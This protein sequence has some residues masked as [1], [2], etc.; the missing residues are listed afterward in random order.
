MKMEVNNSKPTFEPKI[1]KAKISNNEIAKL[2]DSAS[3]SN[4]SVVPAKSD[5]VSLN[6]IL[7]QKDPLTETKSTPQTPPKNELTS[8]GEKY[9]NGPI[10][11]HFKAYRTDPAYKPIV[12]KIDEAGA[13]NVSIKS[14]E[15]VAV[16]TTK[17]IHKNLSAGKTAEVAYNAAM[18]SIVSTK[19]RD[20][21]FVDGGKDKAFHFFTSAALTTKVYNSLPLMPHGMK[22]FIAGNAV[23]TVG[24]LKEVAS[25][26]GNGYGADDMQ[27]NR[28][29]INSALDTISKLRSGKI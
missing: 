14:L 27:A 11:D 16:T 3:V 5:K 24:F 8:L 28:A 18:S 29:G 4:S 15:K 22:S 13:N 19:Y 21:N 17:S 6:P 12:L 26:P 25:I 9:F 2:L 10:L 7:S 1:A 20:P 23:L